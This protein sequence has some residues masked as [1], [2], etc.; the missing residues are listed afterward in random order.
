MFAND[1]FYQAMVEEC[2]HLLHLLGNYEASSGQGINRQKTSIFF[3][4][5][6]RIEVKANIQGLLGA[7]VM[8]DCET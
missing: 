6:T 4:K 1:I 7:R 3:N 2:Q 5:N 8:E